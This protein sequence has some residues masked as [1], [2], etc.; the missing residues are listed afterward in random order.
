MNSDV[1][2]DNRHLPWSIAVYFVVISLLRQNE[3]VLQG[4]YLA[5]HETLP[6]DFKVRAASPEQRYFISQ[7]ANGSGLH[8]ARA[9]F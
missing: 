5:E 3:A 7:C 8:Y 6:M 4:L 1:A 9:D 2:I